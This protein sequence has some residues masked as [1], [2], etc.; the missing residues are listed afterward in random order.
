LPGGV[1][2]DLRLINFEDVIDSRA[3]RPCQVSYFF[4]VNGAYE[5]DPIFGVRNRLQNLLEP[6]AYFAK[7]ELVTTLPKVEDATPVMTDFLQNVMPDVVRVLPDFE[8]VKRG[9]APGPGVQ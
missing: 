6:Y 5:Q 4:Q 2:T 7:I 9:N 8:A 3:S 1:P